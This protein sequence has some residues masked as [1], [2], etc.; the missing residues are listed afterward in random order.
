MKTLVLTFALVLSLAGC[1]SGGGPT[2]EEA[3]NNKMIQADYDATDKLLGTL[4]SPLDREVPIVVATIVNIDN[5]THSS[6]LG[7]LVSEHVAARLSQKGYSVIELKIRGNIFVLQKEGELLL[8]RE[9]KDITRS[10]NAQA[11][12]VGTY[13]KAAGIVYVTLKV[14]GVDE[15]NIVKAAHNYVLPLNENMR[16]L[17]P[18]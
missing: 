16:A 17:L 12:V 6:T 2:Y 13:A 14:V 5:L 18:R 9:L 8:S 10:H 11:V 4:I 1:A 3:A 7:R 15:E